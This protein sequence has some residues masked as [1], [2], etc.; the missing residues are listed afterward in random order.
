MP[1]PRARHQLKLRRRQIPA[2]YIT[3]RRPEMTDDK[4]VRADGW[5]RRSVGLAGFCARIYYLAKAAAD[6]SRRPGH[7]FGV[8]LIQTS[9]RRMESTMPAARGGQS[10]GHQRPAGL[11]LSAGHRARPTLIQACGLRALTLGS[12]Q[13]FALENAR[14][15]ADSARLTR[16][17][18]MGLLAA[19]VCAPSR[20]R[21]APPVS[22]RLK[23]SL[24]GFV[25]GCAATERAR[26][27]SYVH[28]PARRRRSINW[29]GP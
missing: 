2:L 20:L 17:N 24:F 11:S 1:R 23:G 16:H 4:R 14:G 29:S 28:Q 18:E 12:D 27:V 25:L 8:T 3:R 6:E 9:R 26:L 15:L 13:Q 7:P 5:W 22:S 19:G 21:A 10:D